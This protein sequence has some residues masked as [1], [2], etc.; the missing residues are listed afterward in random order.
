MNKVILFSWLAVMVGFGFEAKADSTA[1]C[2]ASATIAPAISGTK[3]TQSP[4]GGDLIFGI[5]M[6]GPSSGTVTITPEN[7]SR[8]SSGGV[9]LVSSL[10]GSASFTVS[11]ATSACYTVTLPGNGIT[12]SN[13][14]TTMAVNSFT[15]YPPSGTGTLGSDGLATFN[16]GGKLE[17]NANQPPGNYTGTF[18]VIIGYQ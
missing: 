16:V 6:P 12:I 7:N 10:A 5:I 13:G 17:V 4:T 2:S 11:G 14:S 3:N 18:N 8:N 1:V 9:Q 15:V